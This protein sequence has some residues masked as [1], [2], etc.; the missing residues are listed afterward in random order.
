M[1]ILFLIIF[2]LALWLSVTFRT[3]VFHPFLAAFYF[4][5]DLYQWFKF[6][7]WRNLQTG[8]I[9]AYVALFGHGKTLSVVH[10]VRSLY[11]RYN[12]R[13]VYDVFRHQWVIQKVH[14]ISNV[15]LS[16]PYED[17][18]S[19]AQV[20]QAATYW[21]QYDLE[22]GT[23]TN[24]LVLGDEF[25]V[26]MNSRN[27]KSNID[28]LFLNTLLTCRHHHITLVYDAQRFNQVDA[29]LRQVTSYVVSCHKVW[30]VLV[31]DKYDAWKLENS[32]DPSKI[33]P[34]LRFGWFIRDRD[35]AAYDTLATVGNLAHSC[36]M[37]DMISDDEILSRQGNNNL[38]VSVSVTSNKKRIV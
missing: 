21:E 26:Q 12:D 15:Q 32:N 30:R 10:Y 37:G 16:I 6:K 28:P 9:I 13:L 31:S 33:R 2:V 22:N 38:D 5:K 18:Q 23:L 14:I 29:L 3:I 7:K 17:F 20:V 1:I 4:F 19:L 34:M 35:F 8:K 36:K 25:S 24:I 27:F 11:D